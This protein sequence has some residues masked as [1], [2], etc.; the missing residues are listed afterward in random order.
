LHRASPSPY[1]DGPAA[2]EGASPAS[3]TTT[4]SVPATAR[5]SA[6]AASW[7][8]HGITSQLGK[9]ER[10]ELLGELEQLEA[11]VMAGIHLAQ[12]HDTDQ[13]KPLR[14]VWDAALHEAGSAPR[15]R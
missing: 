2:E 5:V 12:A 1:L 9:D 6:K 14:S 7:P 4:P 3:P 11:N 10:R 15:A 8:A 13:V